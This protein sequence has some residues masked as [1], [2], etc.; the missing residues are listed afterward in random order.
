MQFYQEIVLGIKNIVDI[1]AVKVLEENVDFFS[2]GVI[3]DN[4]YEVPRAIETML[5]ILQLDMK[6]YF[7][8]Y[9]EIL[10]SSKGDEK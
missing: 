4:D 2:D 8:S 1:Y 5:H 3:I 6:E 10:E 9:E 7:T